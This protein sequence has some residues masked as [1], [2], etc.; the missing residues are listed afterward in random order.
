MIGRFAL[1]MRVAAAIAVLANGLA[2]AGFESCADAGPPAA[3][4]TVGCMR[5]D[6]AALGG[7]TAFSYFVP[8]ACL[9]AVCPTLYLL[10]GF[11][12]DHTSML[13]TKDAPSAWVAALTSGPPVDP[14]GVP[15]PWNYS[16]PAGWTKLA[17][18]DFILIAPHGRT[19]V[20]GFGPAGDLDGFWADWNPRFAAGGDSQRYPTPPPRFETFLLDELIPFVERAF[21]AGRGRAWRALAGTSLGGYGSYKNGLQHPDGWS[22]IGSVSGAHNFLFVPAPDPSD[23][24]ASA[25]SLAPVA[26]LPYQPLPGVL[27]RAPLLPAPLAGFGVALIALGD[28]VADQA[29][30]RGNMPRDLAMNGRASAGGASSLH[31]RGFVNDTIARRAADYEN[32]PGLAGAQAFETIVFP[33][34][35]EMELAFSAEQVERRF[36]IHPGVHSGT[37]WNAFLRGQ[38][39]SQYQHVRHADGG[40]SPPPA[41]TSFD[42]RSIRTDFTVWG[43][44][45]HVE[46]RPIEFLNLRAVSCA[47]LTL[48]GTGKVTVGVPASCG[49]GRGGAPIFEVDL[50]PSYPTDEPAGASAASA[51]GSTAHVALAPPP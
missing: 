45:F 22:S 33:M 36:E 51:Y 40:G 27:S 23:G 16:D 46:R 20:G 41:P 2:R 9:G 13:G 42:Y 28:P 30:F 31:V 35:V 47:G 50:G 34:N 25:P 39:A 6:S 49:T 4:G 12:G 21:P 15:D 11:G 32:P 38:V 5:L 3:V 48:Q 1:Q 7:T 10:H 24:V 19:L 14:R 37:Y 18:I 8:E 29:F 44:S 43:W 17:A 26:P